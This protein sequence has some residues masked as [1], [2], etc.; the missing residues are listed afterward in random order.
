VIPAEIGI[1]L[2]SIIDVAVAAGELP[3][4]ASASTANGTWRPAPVQAGGRP[5]SYATSL[6]FA[7]ARGTSADAR[8]V[9]ARLAASLRQVAWITAA[10]VTGGG[11]LTITVT[12][13][14]LAGLPARVV[15]AGAA[16][17]RSDA[18]AGT[19][20]RAPRNT[21]LGAAPTWEHA[22]REQ[23]AALTG[24]L[25]AAAGAAI[26]F[27]DRE[28]T[29]ARAPSGAGGAGI[30]GTAIAYHGADAVR[31]ALG[32]TSAGDPVPIE[33]QLA[34]PL[35]LGNPFVAVRYAHAD[36]ASTMRWAAELGTGTEGQPAAGLGAMSTS[37]PSAG[38]ATMSA[39]Q[40]TPGRSLLPEELALA[41]AISWLAER[42]AAA[43]RRRR[44]ADLAAH[45]EVLAGAW[46]RCRESCP[47]LPF[48]GAAALPPP[49]IAGR[50]EL[51]AA[52]SVALAAG[53]DLLGVS[54]P[55]RM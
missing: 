27:S 24:K 10:R 8:Q 13:A 31:Y 26:A 29:P 22:W 9:A 19:S 23:R 52:T 7:L 51:A 4:S 28:R 46:L 42:V 1:E 36:S 3:Q 21:D 17:A 33:R 48:Q 14:H 43:A 12:E 41:D 47:A 34:Q 18:L 35:D 16:V 55:G 6:P 44:P 53:L 50:L 32:R 45:L 2:A 49:A 25:A 11:Y 30:V 39:D 40:P 15:A 54:A 38:L 20:L 37:Q 5:G